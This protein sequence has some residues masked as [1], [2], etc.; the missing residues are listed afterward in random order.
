MDP[1]SISFSKLLQKI[2]FEDRIYIYI[3][4]FQIASAEQLAVKGSVCSPPG[5]ISSDLK[6][7]LSDI[8]M[9][10]KLPVDNQL[11]LLNPTYSQG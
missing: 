5:E 3:E 1:N 11:F 9:T 8:D 10:G 6:N 2:P 4:T 7:T